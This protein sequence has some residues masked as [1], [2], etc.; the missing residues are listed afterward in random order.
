MQILYVN[1][2]KIIFSDA[3]L[4]EMKQWLNKQI[5][6]SIKVFPVNCSFAGYE[7]LVWIPLQNSQI[8]KSV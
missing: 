5:F 4:L 8:L 3:Q 1:E 7:N 2:K 6:K